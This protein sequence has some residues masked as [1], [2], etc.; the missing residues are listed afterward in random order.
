MPAVILSSRHAELA[1]VLGHTAHRPDACI[2]RG[3]ADLDPTRDIAWDLAVK[4]GRTDPAG[5]AKVPAD[6]PYSFDAGV[7]TVL[8][9]AERLA[10]LT[11]SPV[12]AAQLRAALEG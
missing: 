12:S 4:A 10:R 5:C 1:A 8:A 3:D 6:A 7:R 2:V 11:Q 9:Q